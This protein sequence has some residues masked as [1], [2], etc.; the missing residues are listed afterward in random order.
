MKAL[1]LAHQASSLTQQQSLHDLR[2]E[3]IHKRTRGSMTRVKCVDQRESPRGS[4]EKGETTSGMGKVA[5]DLTR[6]MFF[7]HSFILECLTQ[8]YG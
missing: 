8:P 7:E 1:M 6:E 2:R 5:F 3:E 4:Y